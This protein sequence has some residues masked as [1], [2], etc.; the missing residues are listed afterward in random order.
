MPARNLATSYLHLQHKRSLLL[1][2]KAFLKDKLA[3]VQGA[4]A[5]VNQGLR[6]LKKS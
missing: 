3:F 4:L 1:A 5:T 2:E 6:A